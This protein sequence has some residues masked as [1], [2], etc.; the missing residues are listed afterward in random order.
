MLL[1]G[2]A[3]DVLNFEIFQQAFDF[4]HAGYA[5]ALSMVLFLILLIITLL[6]VLF[7]RSRTVY[8]LS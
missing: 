5:S 6:Q 7:F 2:D 1:S 3:T 4:F 8:D